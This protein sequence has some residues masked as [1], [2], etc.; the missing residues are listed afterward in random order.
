MNKQQREAVL[1]S[2]KKCVD[3][4]EQISCNEDGIWK[5]SIGE[6]YLYIASDGAICD[7]TWEESDSDYGIL[8]LGNIYKSLD[9]AEFE[10]NRKELLVELK[11]FSSKFKVGELNWTLSYERFSKEIR[12]ELLHS[13]NVLCPEICFPSKFLAEEAISDIGPSRIMKYL[14]RVKTADHH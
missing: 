10:K 1:Q 11:R 2:L 9:E 8:R 7:A 13:N 3:Q 4:I 6:R 12:I 5:P 14:F